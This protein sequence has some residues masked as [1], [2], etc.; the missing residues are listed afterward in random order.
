MAETKT[1]ATRLAFGQE[2]ARIGAREDI[3]AMDADL[4]C[5]TMTSL[6]RDQYPE[7][8]INCGIAEGNMMATAA[9][10]ASCGKKVF[11][12]S[13]AMFAT[14]RA[15]EQIRNSI[16]YPELNVV[17]VGSHSGV[18]VGEDGAS[19][20]C[21]EDVALM[22]AIPGMSVVSPADAT[23]ARAAVRALAEYDKPAYLRL[24]RLAMPVLFDE[25]EYGEFEIGKGRIL[26]EGTDVTVIAAGLLLHEAVKAVE[27][28]SAQGVSVRFVDMATI[29]PID[30]ALV[31]DSAKKTGAIV[32]VEEHSVIGGLGSAVA[33][34]LVR[35][36]P[37]PMEIVGVKDKFGRS[38]KPAELLDLYEMSAPHI[39]ARVRDVLARKK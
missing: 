8:H 9:G 31:I 33:D 38:G 20:Q 10:L 21:I 19:H 28:L 6:F 34:V 30:E 3:M 1:I 18:T 22:R 5:S 29:K 13:F 32:C 36:C 17:V 24:S 37:V 25:K 16:G 35:N 27:Q 7:R 14:G 2:L 12:A 15:Y 26:Q 39:V 4:S 23:E 11:A